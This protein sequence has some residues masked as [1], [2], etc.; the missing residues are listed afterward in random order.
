MTTFSSGS[1]SLAIPCF[2]LAPH[3]LMLAVASSPHG[4]KTALTGVATLFQAHLIQPGRAL[5][6]RTPGKILLSRVLTATSVTS[7]RTPIIKTDHTRWLKW[8][9]GETAKQPQE[10]IWATTYPQDRREARALFSPKRQSKPLQHLFESNGP[11]S[12]A[13]GQSRNAFRKG[14]S[15]AGRLLAKEA[16]D[17]DHQ[18]NSMTAPG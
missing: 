18:P 10:R 15:R 13:L 4:S 3:R 12:I 16:M 8:I 11:A 5:G 17:L 9:I 2:A 7:C 1:P 6:G 14:L